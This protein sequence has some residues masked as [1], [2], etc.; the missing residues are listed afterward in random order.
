MTLQEIKNAVDKYGFYEVL[1]I[2]AGEDW[3]FTKAAQAYWDKQS[4]STVDRFAQ[5]INSL[6]KWVLDFVWG[7]IRSIYKGFYYLAIAL[8]SV[9]G[10]LFFGTDH[11]I[12]KTVEGMPGLGDLPILLVNVPIRALAPIGEMIIGTVQNIN[13]SL[14]VTI[15]AQGGPL[16]API[17]AA[18]QI[19]E[20]GLLFYLVWVG[21]TFAATI[22]GVATLV[23]GAKVALR[24]FK[25]AVEVIR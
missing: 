17:L 14:V 10:V 11:S 25:A 24:P 12:E 21:A 5:L 18:I 4:S 6:K 19:A 8:V 15:T 9:V 13:N 20:I 2:G 3:E 1:R 16:T 22:P 23:A 7:I